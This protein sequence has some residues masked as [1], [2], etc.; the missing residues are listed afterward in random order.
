MILAYTYEYT[1]T[2]L[3]FRNLKLAYRRCAY[4]QKVI[5][6]SRVRKVIETACYV[7]WSRIL[8]KKN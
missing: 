6:R 7:L 5:Y 4:F 2:L 3:D 8:S 1:K